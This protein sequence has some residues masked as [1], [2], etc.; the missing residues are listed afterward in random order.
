MDVD[1]IPFG[2]DFRDLIRHTVRECKVL[3]A[4]IG[5]R[6]LGFSAEHRCKILDPDD[7]VRIELEEAINIK[8]PIVPVLVDGTLMPSENDL[9]ESLEGLCYFNAARVACGAD[10][11]IHIKR[12]I[13]GLEGYVGEV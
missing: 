12:L 7:F 4:V 1:S 11:D 6:W 3:I 9:P 8:L 5:E 13:L 2:V 10:F